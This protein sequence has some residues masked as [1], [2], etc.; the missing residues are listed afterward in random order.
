MKKPNLS[1]AVL[2]AFALAVVSCQK[3]TTPVDPVP[4][5]SGSIE[6][7][8][9]V[10]IPYS[11]TNMQQALEKVA[12]EKY[13]QTATV[14][15]LKE[16]GIYL[17]FR[18]KDRNELAFLQAR[19]FE[20]FD[21]PL[22]RKIKKWGNHYGSQDYSDKSFPWYYTVLRN[23]QNSA[24]YLSSYGID[25][26]EHEILEL[27]FIPDPDA[28]FSVQGISGTAGIVTGEEVERRALIA[29][30]YPVRDDTKTDTRQT[31][32][33]RIRVYDDIHKEYVGAKGVKVRRQLSIRVDTTYTDGNGNYKFNREFPGTPCYS[34]V[35]EN[36]KDF[37]IWY[38]LNFIEAAVHNFGKQ[39]SG[40]S[41]DFNKNDDDPEGWRC[42]VINNSAYDYYTMCSTDGIK[43]PPDDL[44]IWCWTF[45]G[46]S[47]ASMIRRVA[48][49]GSGWVDTKIVGFIM[50]F[51]EG[52]SDD[53]K[54]KIANLILHALPDLT[55]GT[56]SSYYNTYARHYIVTWHELTHSSHYQQV[57]NGIWGKYIDYIVENLGYGDSSSKPGTGKDIC[58]LS[59][60]WAYANEHLCKDQKFG[61]YYYPLSLEGE[62]FNPYYEE[63]YDSLNSGIWTVKQIYDFL[64]PEVTSYE[65]LKKELLKP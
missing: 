6:L 14:P 15:Q 30:G 54:T 48:G 24:T 46:S 34:V 58:G 55:I 42:S 9:E 44:K 43:L 52:D 49:T 4:Q 56:Y 12:K 31:T 61:N 37:S 62:W 29:A 3:E 35:F 65:A 40:F 36:S 50:S 47:S 19:K 13:G 20:F 10:P 57:G 7:G 41:Y 25:K 17:R 18:P 32:E 39:E 59:E 21:Y 23:V 1:C 8:E 22:D 60:S 64:T 38:N 27:C 28:E 63:L 2:V 45:A 33:G 51:A 11:V 16:N 5:D 26:I 53:I